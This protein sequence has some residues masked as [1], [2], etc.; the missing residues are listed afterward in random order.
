MAEIESMSPAQ[1]SLYLDRIG[2]G[3]PRPLAPTLSVLVALHRAHSFSIPYEL[4]DFIIPPS[5]G[6]RRISET[7]SLP[8]S[9]RLEDIFHILVT[10][11]RGGACVYQNLLLAAALKAVGFT[12]VESWAAIGQLEHRMAGYKPGKPLPGEGHMII[13][14]MCE[15][16]RFLCDLGSPAD[17]LMQ[18]V[19]LVLDVI[20]P[21]NP[22]ASFQLRV[23]PEDTSYTELRTLRQNKWTR[24]LAF[25]P[26]ARTGGRIL[27]PALEALNEVPLLQNVI[28]VRPHPEGSDQLVDRRLKQRR[29]LTTTTRV[30]TTPAEYEQALRD[31]F[32]IEDFSV[33]SVLP[34][35]LKM[36]NFPADAGVKKVAAGGKD[37]RL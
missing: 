19:Q 29:G 5:R 28:I 15:C 20:Q 16:R 30:L 21:V 32:G 13:A 9:Y 17:G 24:C 8:V 25:R 2:Y 22:W 31:V 6:G 7:E 23:F 3:G 4:L 14:V 1:L 18:P 26:V 34:F 35:A 12:G 27:A 37:A 33:S 11:R 10:R 36:L